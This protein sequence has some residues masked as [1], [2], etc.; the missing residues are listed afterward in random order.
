MAENTAAGKLDGWVW[1]CIYLGMLLLGV[2]LAV[3]RTDSALGWSIATAATLLIALG[4]VLVW[5]R[6]RIKTPQ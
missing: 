1:V 2:G 4:I 6:S 5:A 3:A